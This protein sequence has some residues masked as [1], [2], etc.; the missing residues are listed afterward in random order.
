MNFPRRNRIDQYTPA[1]T[2]IYEA[3]QA[4]EAAGAHPRL[5]DAINLLAD[6]QAAVADFVDGTT[7][8]YL[9]YREAPPPAAPVPVQQEAPKPLCPQPGHGKKFMHGDTLLCMECGGLVPATPQAGRYISPNELETIAE[10]LGWAR[11]LLPS[12]AQCAAMVAEIR[13][14]WANH[15][16]AP[17]KMVP[18]ISREG[19]TLETIQA[20]NESRYVSTSSHYAGQV[21]LEGHFDV[22][23]LKRII[24]VLAPSQ[25]PG[26]ATS[27]SE[28]P[29][30]SSSEIPDNS[31][32]DKNGH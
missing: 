22:A 26:E 17:G 4:V 8:A 24:R 29:K 7:T 9:H 18:A 13:E 1:E 27:P 32:K 28:P 23:T 2:A 30:G 16:T 20:E 19:E 6:A 12:V 11:P 31:T 21:Q 14:G 3:V 5:T 25:A 15:I 10:Q